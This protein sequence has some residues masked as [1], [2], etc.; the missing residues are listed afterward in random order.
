MSEKRGKRTRFMVEPR[1]QGRLSFM[2]AGYLGV[3]GAVMGAAFFAPTLWALLR[4]RPYEE[5]LAAARSAVWVDFGP[6]VVA[7]LLAAAA[8]AHFVTYTHRVF[9]PLVRLR[10]SFQRWRED[11]VWPPRLYVRRRDFHQRLFEAFNQASGELAADVS[12]VREGLRSVADR[13]RLLP[14]GD[15]PL[16]AAEVRRAEHECRYLLGRLDRWTIGETAPS[17]RTPAAPGSP[18]GGRPP[19]RPDQPEG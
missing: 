1:A 13:L 15:D 11:Q 18:E 19:Q 5:L 17:G 6:I 16:T 8:A 2:V 12:T 3:F 9:G 14:A 4:G 7:S 10:K